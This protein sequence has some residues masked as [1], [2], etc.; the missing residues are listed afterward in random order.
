MILGCVDKRRVLIHVSPPNPHPP[1]RAKCRTI[2]LPLTCLGVFSASQS[3][4]H[5]DPTVPACTR[6]RPAA[7]PIAAGASDHRTK[8]TRTAAPHI[9]CE[10]SRHFQPRITSS[11]ASASPTL[12]VETM[13]TTSKPSS[14]VL[15]HLSRSINYIHL[16][17][18]CHSIIEWPQLLKPVMA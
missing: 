1:Q 8:I 15:R 9:C 7:T 11:T 6:R 4:P 5:Q 17:N 14:P 3:Q 12:A 2:V 10:P 13:S 18:T 16:Q